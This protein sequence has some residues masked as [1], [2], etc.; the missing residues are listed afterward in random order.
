MAGVLEEDCELVIG[1]RVFGD[2]EGWDLERV[3]GAFPLHPGP[4]HA[5]L[6]GVGVQCVDLAVRRSEECPAPL[7]GLHGRNLP[8]GEAGLV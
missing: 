7:Y 1:H 3:A 5:E 8:F 6:C 2:V 4:L